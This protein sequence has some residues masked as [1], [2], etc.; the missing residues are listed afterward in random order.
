MTT[1]HETFLQYAQHLKALGF[2]VYVSTDANYNYGFYSHAASLHKVIYFQYNGVSGLSFTHKCTPKE[3][4]GSGC[5]I[6]FEKDLTYKNMLNLLKDPMPDWY[7]RPESDRL[8]L[9]QCID[10]KV[11]EL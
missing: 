3:F 1:S 2:V 6:D 10:Y 11:K 9:K 7:N 4:K 5:T 8:S